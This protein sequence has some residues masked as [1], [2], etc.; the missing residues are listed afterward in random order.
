MEIKKLLMLTQ[1]GREMKYTDLEEGTSDILVFQNMENIYMSIA[2]EDL[3]AIDKNGGVHTAKKGDI[4]IKSNCE[5]VYGV[6]PAS[7]N[8]AEL[9][10]FVKEQKDIKRKE[11]STK[12]KAMPM[13][14]SETCPSTREAR[15]PDDRDDPVRESMDDRVVS[16]VS[17]SY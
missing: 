8:M 10:G 7:Y 9:L 15:E 2:P 5:E 6:V 11:R 4:I 1:S 14:T 13:T 3:T 12:T 16:C 17:E